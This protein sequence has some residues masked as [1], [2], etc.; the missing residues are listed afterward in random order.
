[1]IVSEVTSPMEF[2]LQYPGSKDLEKLENDLSKY[3]GK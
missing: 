1:M 3:D 2:Y